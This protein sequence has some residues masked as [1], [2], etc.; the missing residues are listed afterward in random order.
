MIY[1]FYSSA[2]Y[3]ETLTF[4]ILKKYPNLDVEYWA[5]LYYSILNLSPYSLSW[6]FLYIILDLSPYP[7]SWTFPNPLL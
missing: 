4:N 6:A 3:M 7:L 1:L 2:I 5:F